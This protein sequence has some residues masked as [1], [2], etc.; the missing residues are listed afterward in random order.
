MRSA[1]GVGPRE[2]LYVSLQNVGFYLNR[3]FGPLLNKISSAYNVVKVY[4]PRGFEVI[5]A[6]TLGGRA[7]IYNLKIEGRRA[8]SMAAWL[9]GLIAS[10]YL[11]V[12]DGDVYVDLG[13]ERVV[14]PLESLLLAPYAS[15]ALHSLA[16]LVALRSLGGKCAKFKDG[17]VCSFRGLKFFARRLAEIDLPL[18]EDLYDGPLLGAS[19][20][21]FEFEFFTKVLKSSDRPFVVDVGAY[22]GAYT[23][24]ACTRGASVIALEPDS[25]T[26]GF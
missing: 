7:R 20:E 19:R 2:R 4:G 11:R 26:S 15:I 5:K 13:G 12:E 3:V 21:K 16:M 22:I 10:G 14:V 1:E 8:I 6:Y 24:E 17:F 25:E 18:P 23:V 9:A